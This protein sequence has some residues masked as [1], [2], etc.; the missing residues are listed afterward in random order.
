MISCQNKI[1][2]AYVLKKT[3]MQSTHPLLKF[4]QLKW[5][6]H[7]IR[8]PD[9]W[10]PRKVFYGVLQV[11]KGFQGG[12]KKHF[13]GALKAFL[14]DLSILY[15]QSSGNKLRMVEQSC[16]ASSER[17]KTTMKPR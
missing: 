11:G 3:V 4:A 9:K 14:K 5:T 7:V 2:D 10:L 15:L 16:I 13:K 17:E 6:G 8:M 12:Q 1:F